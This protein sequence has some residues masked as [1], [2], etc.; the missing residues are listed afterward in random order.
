ML[1]LLEKDFVAE[2][3]CTAFVLRLL[4][5]CKV[6]TFS[7][8]SL[9][10]PPTS[11]VFLFLYH[12]AALLVTE[13]DPSEHG[14]MVVSLLLL[15]YLFIEGVALCNSSDGVHGAFFDVNEEAKAVL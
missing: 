14:V 10:N 12:L 8:S 7:S 6:V 13:G 3:F 4:L 15:L 1:G 2:E 5:P 9:L 11:T